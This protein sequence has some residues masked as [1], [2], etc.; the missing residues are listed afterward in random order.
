MLRTSSRAASAPAMAAAAVAAMLVVAS[1]FGGVD[2]VVDPT[3][4]WSDC[5]GPADHPTVGQGNYYN[6]CIKD[7]SFV[8]KNFAWTFTLSN[9][10]N[11][12]F[13]GCT[14]SNNPS[15][16]MNLSY[17]KWSNVKFIKTSFSSFTNDPISFDN[18]VFQNVVFDSCTFQSAARV[19]FSRFEFMNVMFLNC[20]FGSD[21]LFELGQMTQTFFNNTIFSSSPNAKTPAEN[22]A[23]RFS[24]VTVRQAY[25]TGCTVVNPIYFQNAAVAN[26]Q[27]NKT[28]LGAF[29]CHE[30]PKKNKNPQ[31]FSGFN[32]SSFDRVTFGGKMSCDRTTWKGMAITNSVFADDA[33]FSKSNILD[34]YWI[35]VDFKAPDKSC[36]KLDM[37]N[38]VVERK[39]MANTTVSCIAT[40]A[41]TRFD[42]V[43]VQ[44]FNAKRPD[45]KDAL[46]SDQEYI[47]GQCCTRA[48]LSLGCKCNVT[49][50][51]GQCP[52]G[53]SKVNINAASNCFAADG[54][55]ALENGDVV[56][57]DQLAHSDRV[58]VGGGAHSDVFFFGHRNADASG[59]F[60]RIES[61]LNSAGP[62]FISPGHYLY[63]NGKLATADTVR[64]GDKL[65]GP[66]NKDNVAVLTI[67]HEERTGLYAPASLHGD[68]LVDGIVV[69]SYTDVMH[70]TTAHNLLAPIRWL[71]DTSLRPLVHRTSSVMH[72]DSFSWL[73]RRFRVPEGPK[74]VNI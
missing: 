15:K 28:I 7:H 46:F 12:T 56:R 61:T 14:F 24:S 30:A 53:S 32:D 43:Y 34:L 20:Q 66:D 60:V 63:V 52:V 49:Q 8:N 45:F 13:T 42:H 17:A 64:I 39:L 23:V 9:L 51:S 19:V 37:S 67:A 4:M 38:C 68:L 11:T 29:W 62:L 74:V 25:F 69:S 50:P 58:A 5:T 41:G 40:F 54:T 6:L 3:I 70:P 31:L 55:L 10:M 2:A 18:S 47:D 21:A 35:K 27:M 65:R 22:T 44:N 1:M 16:K 33:D 59:L 72:A 36:H 57:M 48:C 73:A 71:Y 26:L